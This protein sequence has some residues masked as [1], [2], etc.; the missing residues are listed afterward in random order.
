MKPVVIIAIAVGC[1][2]AGTLGVLIAWQGVATMQAQEVYDEIQSQQLQ[3]QYYQEE[4]ST[5]AYNINREVCVELYGNSMSMAGESNDYADCLDYGATMVVERSIRDCDYEWKAV[6]LKCELERHVNYYNSMMPKLQAL[7]E[8]HRIDMGY[9]SETMKALS[10]DWTMKGNLLT[11]T[12]QSIEE[13]LESPE[14]FLNKSPS[15]S[16]QPSNPEFENM[17]FSQISIEY[18][19]C[20]D[21]ISHQG[22]NCDNLL[23]EMLHP[24]CLELQNFIHFDNELNR[25]K[26]L[27]YNEIRNTERS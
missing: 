17:T 21:G 10:D 12:H 16:E 18:F 25:C 8:Q 6:S 15:F 9:D 5:I 11:A 14:D 23:N 19:A 20:V 7:S 1:S 27:N 2:V 13:F 24:Y 4:L 26:N 22:K 3:E